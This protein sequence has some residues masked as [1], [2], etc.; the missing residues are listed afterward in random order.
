MIC[1]K[2]FIFK[3]IIINSFYN[4][5]VNYTDVVVG[6]F[7]S[8]V[9]NDGVREDRFAESSGESIF[10]HGE[11]KGREDNLNALYVASFIDRGTVRDFQ[12]R[13]LQIRC[14][15]GKCIISKNRISLKQIRNSNS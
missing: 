5:F 12:F 13:H 2:I 4:I 15:R 10:T 3:I 9:L 8:D 14:R 7:S 11:N 6:Q 1:I